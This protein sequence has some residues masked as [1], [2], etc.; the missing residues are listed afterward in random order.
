M[1]LDQ[2]RRENKGLNSQLRDNLKSIQKR[3]SKALS[4]SFHP[5]RNVTLIAVS[6]KQPLEKISAL[7]GLG[8]IDFGENYVQEA[9]E[10]MEALSHPGLRWHF[11][12]GLQTNKARYVPGKFSLVHS[13]DSAKLARALHNKAKSLDIVQPVLVQVNLAG[14]SQKSGA[15]KQDLP[16]LAEVILELSHLR[17]EGLMLMP[18]FFDDPEKARPYFAGMRMLGRSL[19][20]SLGV[21]LP[22]LS[23]GMSGD[24]EV[25]VE[26]GSTMVRIGE[27]LFG[28]RPG[29]K[30]T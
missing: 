2:Q 13:V 5:N 15:A 10:K 23:M 22:H 7:A 17:L 20:H 28:P 4:K 19:E 21:R 16:E 27:S 30:L 24:F 14:E 12:G 9:L 18:P 3:I 26:E 29:G 8:Q 25:A 6:K 11:I 1:N